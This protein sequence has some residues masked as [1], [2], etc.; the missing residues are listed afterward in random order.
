MTEGQHTNSKAESALPPAI[1]KFFRAAIKAKA[2]DL[3]LKVGQMPKLRMHGRLKNTNVEPLT[4][5]QMEKLIFGIMTEKQKET[6][7]KKGAVDFTHQ[8][9]QTARFRTNVFRQQG[10]MSLVARQIAS[11]VPP[12]ESLHLPDIIKVIAESQ[13]GLVLV[14]GPSGCGKTTTIASMIDHINT[15]RSCHIMTIEEPIEFIHKDKKAIISQREIPT[16]V[17]TYEESFVSLTRQDI[18]VVMFGEMT[19]RVT[20]S[21]AMATA[22]A[23]HLVIGTMHAASASQTIQRVLNIFPSNERDLARQTL[24]NS[25]KAIINQKLLPSVKPEIPSIPSVEVLIN[26]AACSKYI[27]E[28][29]DSELP[30]LIRQCQEEGMM[31]F[32]ESLR[33]LVVGE[34]VDLKVAQRYAPNIEELTMAI[35]GIRT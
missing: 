6:F 27:A 20:L 9:G 25:L 23:G 16:D 3:H 30:G 1:D 14:T 32:T 7:L 2:S 29:K 31:D 35:R 15:V 21:A 4:Q 12:F 10:M 34:W 11:E 8:V 22:E 13:E 5:D 24:S 19:D 18:D 17:L 33:I 28:K 26:N